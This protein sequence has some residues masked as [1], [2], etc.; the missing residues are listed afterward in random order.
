[1]LPPASHGAHA[2]A[3]AQRAP[4][5]VPRSQAGLRVAL[6]HAALGA[7][8]VLLASSIARAPGDAAQRTRGAAGGGAALAAQA[9]LAAASR[10]R[11]L[12]GGGVDAIGAASPASAAAARRVAA[13]AALSDALAEE[14]DALRAELKAL[15]EGAV[16]AAVP[17]PAAAEAARTLNSQDKP[18]VPLVP[19][20]TVTAALSSTSGQRA[21]APAPTKPVAVP[22]R[23]AGT[24]GS[25]VSA[26][27]QP[28]VYKPVSRGFVCFENLYLLS[29]RVKV[30]LPPQPSP[31]LLAFLAGDARESQISALTAE[32]EE[33]LAGSGPLPSISSAH[34]MFEWTMNLFLRHHFHFAELMA[35]HLFM[36]AATE[37]P[38]AELVLICGHIA[39]RYD[40]GLNGQNGLNALVAAAAWAGAPLARCEEVNGSSALSSDGASLISPAS[41]PPSW[42]WTRAD[43]NRV[44][45]SQRA[46]VPLEPLS[47]PRIDWC[48]RTPGAMPRGRLP[49]AL[50]VKRACTS[51]RKAAHRDPQ[52]SVQNN[53]NAGLVAQVNSNVQERIDAALSAHLRS[54]ELV[55]GAEFAADVKDITG[56]GIAEMLARPAVVG[57]P[58]I[59]AIQRSNRRSIADAS[60]TE[61]VALL[62]AKYSSRVLA[63]RMELLS[64]RQQ[65]R[66]ASIADI[67]VAA[68]GMGLCNL[69]WQR[70]GSGVLEIFPHVR[71]ISMCPI[72]C[73]QMLTPPR[74]FLAVQ[75][76]RNP[77]HWLDERLTFY[78]SAQGR[79]LPL[80][81]QPAGPR[82][83]GWPQHLR[84]RA[85]AAHQHRRGEHD[86][87]R[88]RA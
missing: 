33:A 57:E 38:P 81:G 5:C 51:D 7:C 4:T 26:P 24:G 31:D 49:W 43:L 61:L 77:G 29:G 34:V 30:L 63:V 37:L 45:D 62:R 12:S 53:V 18:P 2:A 84:P 28:T 39:Q 70:R 87:R 46:G 19:P 10:V 67:F 58:L 47:P 86:G 80:H 82:Q 8:L 64:P 68:H 88:A 25:C 3:A 23:S 69:L 9:A 72:H 73:L 85:P 55:A 20:A 83:P 14:G 44:G 52:T 48:A 22:G 65:L 15:R 74:S 56:V 21:G 50:H 42:E 40:D 6:A 66:L 13:L 71:A 36:E 41:M 1:M 75:P 78:V 16:L 54:S 17:A 79:H 76:R 11:A 59:V 60:F 27:L 32:E 35:S